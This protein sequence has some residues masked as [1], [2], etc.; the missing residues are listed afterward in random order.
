MS[1]GL[2]ETAFILTRRS[3]GPIVGLG[4]LVSRR[5]FSSSMGSESVMAIIFMLLSIKFMISGGVWALSSG[6]G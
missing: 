5:A 4:A 1:T 6:G 2:M 3:F